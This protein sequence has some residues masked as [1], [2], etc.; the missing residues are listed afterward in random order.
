MK[1]AAVLLFPLILC[2]GCTQRYVYPSS[3]KLVFT[4]ANPRCGN[5]WLFQDEVYTD[6]FGVTRD[7]R[8]NRTVKLV[9]EVSRLYLMQH[10]RDERS[11]DALVIAHPEEE[12]IT[13]EDGMKR[14]E[15]RL[16]QRAEIAYERMECM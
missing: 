6:A 14:A 7:I 2:L 3:Y 10:Y 9:G 5:I 8:T 4:Y 12:V 1:F 13:I 15:N 11:R 16:L